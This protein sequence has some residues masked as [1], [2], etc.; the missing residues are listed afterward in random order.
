[1]G[2]RRDLLHTGRRDL[3]GIGELLDIGGTCVT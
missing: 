2:Y 3:R 1:M